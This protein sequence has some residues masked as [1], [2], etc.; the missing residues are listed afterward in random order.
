MACTSYHSV[1]RDSA[2]SHTRTRTRTHARTRART[3]ARTHA[4]A[5]ARTHTHTPLEH[6]GDVCVCVCLSVCLLHCRGLLSCELLSTFEKQLPHWAYC[7]ATFPNKRIKKKGAALLGVLLCD[8]S[9]LEGALESTHAV[10]GAVER[11]RIR[12]ALREGF[13]VPWQTFSKVSVMTF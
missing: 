3:H 1:T 12:R 2:L 11:R 6:M 7:S 13:H 9:G 5:H 10:H 8:F 4:H